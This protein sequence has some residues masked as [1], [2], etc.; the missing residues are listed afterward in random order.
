MLTHTLTDPQGKK[1]NITEEQALSYNQGNNRLAKGFQVTPIETARPTSPIV[2]PV[3]AKS[4]KPAPE[5]Q[6][7]TPQAPQDNLVYAE[8]V[9]GAVDSARK[10]LDTTLAN[11]KSTIDTQVD[12]LRKQQADTLAKAKPLTEPF[13]AELENTE[14]RKKFVDDNFEANQRL[15]NELDSLLT[16]QNALMA[17]AMGGA[18]MSNRARQ[19]KVNRTQQE[20]SARVGVIEAVMNARNNQIAQAYT[21]I[22]RSIG[23]IASDRNDSLNY[24]N[25]LIE[26]DNQRI[27]TLDNE[28]R[29]I[30][31]EQISLV[32][33]DLAKA[34][35]TAE[36]VKELMLD[37]TTAQF[38]ADAGVTLLDSVDE[39]K[40]KM[41]E[42]GKREDII[43]I[44][45]SLVEQGYEIVPYEA[46]GSFPVEVG[47]KTLY[48]KVR[49]GS[50][51][52]LQIEAQRAQTA[53]IYDQIRAR[54]ESANDVMLK[55]TT[56]AEKKEAERKIKSEQ[57]LGMNQI[58]KDLGSMPGMSSAVGFGV[59]KS[60]LARFGV[61]A[62]A[63]A[64]AGGAGGTVV[65]P[66]GTV[67]GAV[68]GALVGGFGG[69]KIGSDAIAGS[70]RADFET[71][72]NRL[73]DMFLVD[74]L[75]K[76]TG[77]LTDKDLEVLRSEGTTIGNFN[78]SE[79][80]WL[81]ELERL[82]AMVQRGI[83]ENGITSEQAVF[84]ELIDE[85][86]AQSL[87]A[88]WDNL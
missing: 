24:Y 72:A 57:A 19:I 63:G 25:T 56:E 45:N 26:L 64:L 73:S 68:G 2:T 5:V 30:T 31:N 48:A 76:M 39:V 7:P 43:S 51:L 18:I 83:R 54:V 17:Q 4:L 13:R 87:D 9:K 1:I 85:N 38:M 84:Y 28:S 12:A 82:Q 61:G 15:T 70:A 22:D 34:E 6:L 41:A 44:K 36:Y 32:K 49:P 42:Q 88:I 60:P 8:T 55:A 58:L 66:V 79:K 78:Q 20:V 21:A 11:E 50:P 16:Q 81:K 29:K 37:P 23:N 62:G 74:N 71:Q 3:P 59:K 53:N 46:E 14:R 40:T 35:K 10:T 86:D 69:L 67:A 52:A 65:G 27:L 80:A 75:S 77:V 47:G 33:G